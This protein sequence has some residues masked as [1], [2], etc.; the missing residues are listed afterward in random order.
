VARF[1]ARLKPLACAKTTFGYRCAA[2]TVPSMNPKLVV[3][4]TFAPCPTSRSMNGSTFP[5][6][7][8]ST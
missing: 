8:D 2:A 4:I 1:R 6:G 7:T 3:K 5:S